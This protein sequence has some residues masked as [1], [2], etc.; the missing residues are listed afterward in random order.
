MM[1]GFGHAGFEDE[2][3]KSALEEVLDS[4]SEDVIEL[5]LGLVQ[6]TIPIHMPQQGFSFEYPM[7]VFLIQRQKHTRCISYVA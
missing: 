6:E 3:L 2:S 1:D 4:E 7:R 5:V